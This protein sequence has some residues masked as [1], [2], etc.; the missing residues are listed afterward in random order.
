MLEVAVMGL[1]MR[2]RRIPGWYRRLVVSTSVWIRTLFWNTGVCFQKS[3]FCWPP[4]LV[5]G[6]LT[7]WLASL[8]TNVSLLSLW[9]PPSD[10]SSQCSAIMDDSAEYGYRGRR[11]GPHPDSSGRR[12]RASFV[13]KHIVWLERQSQTSRQPQARARHQMGG[14]CS[15]EGDREG[16]K[17]QSH[18][19]RDTE[20]Q[21]KDCKETLSHSCLLSHCRWDYANESFK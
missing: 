5:K 20:K 21:E 16:V 13:P 7:F 19:W 9:M 8:L 10:N 14:R 4:E 3:F 11:E 17:D 18:F 2:V 1:M 15:R 12:K 6:D